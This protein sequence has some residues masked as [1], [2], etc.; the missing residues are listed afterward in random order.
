MGLSDSYHPGERL[1]C[2]RE[3]N[4]MVVRSLYPNQHG[5]RLDE[6][7]RLDGRT[8]EIMKKTPWQTFRFAFIYLNSQP[9][10]YLITILISSSSY[11]G[12]IAILSGS[13]L[14]FLILWCTIRLG[15]WDPERPW[16]DFGEELVGKWIHSL[17]L[18]LLSFYAVTFAAVDIESFTLFYGSNYMRE[19]PQWFIQI[20]LGV[21]III[22]ARWGFK[23]LVY[24]SDGLFFFTVAALV[25]T[26][27][28]F[29]KD[30]DLHMLTG[31][32]THHNYGTLAKD[33]IIV[34]SY[35]GEWIMFLFIAPYIQIGWRTMR[36]LFCAGLL[37]TLAVAL[38]WVLTFLNFGPH[39]GKM[40]QFPLIELL[41]S[42]I[43]GLLGNSDPLIIG[44]WSS[45]MFI[46]SAFLI[47]VAA[48]CF[49]KVIRTQRMQLTLVTLLGG[50]ATVIAYQFSRDPTLYQQ[51][52]SELSVTVFWVSVECIPVFY[53]IVTLFRHKKK[54]SD[55]PPSSS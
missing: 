44:L 19:T 36:N 23:T 33:T 8:E 14:S 4:L 52:I 1:E 3:S 51:N 38:Q 12:W 48:R 26:I 46:H 18:L 40:L 2:E 20:I 43:T 13:V 22:T 9:T 11:L 45:S 21:V 39:L 7:G 31:F 34:L 54:P 42:S 10:A 49:A 17:V 35:F 37:V 32:V 50:C 41:R 5:F 16:L 6:L 53:W 47:H 24:L 29:A 28:S 25:L 30:A 55:S 15:M 27:S